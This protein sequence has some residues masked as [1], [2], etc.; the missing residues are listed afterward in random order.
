MRLLACVSVFFAITVG[1]FSQQWEVQKYGSDWDIYCYCHNVEPAVTIFASL[2]GDGRLRASVRPHAYGINYMLYGTEVK[3]LPSYQVGGAWAGPT[4]MRFKGRPRENSD[5]TMSVKFSAKDGNFSVNNGTLTLFP[6]DVSRPNLVVTL[7]MDYAVKQPR[8]RRAVP[9][10]LDTNVAGGAFRPLTLLSQRQGIERDYNT[11]DY[12][13]CQAY[14]LVSGNAYLFP[15]TDGWIV[16][17][18]NNLMSSNIGLPGVMWPVRYGTT[19]MYY[20]T[21]EVVNTP[22]AVIGGWFYPSDDRSA[23]NVSLWQGVDSVPTG[24]GATIVVSVP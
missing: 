13:R 7:S 14:A 2:T 20:S 9:F 4:S 12:R 23:Y 5:G 11:L 10:V 16:D 15:V 22:L 1:G 17:P 21:V 3:L 6:I 24:W 8:G 18:A 19:K